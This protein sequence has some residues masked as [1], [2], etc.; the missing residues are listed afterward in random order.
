VQP[1]SSVLFG[2]RWSNNL[3]SF[4]WFGVTKERVRVWCVRFGFGSIP[5]TTAL[6]DF[7]CRGILGA[8]FSFSRRSK[9]LPVRGCLSDT[10]ASR[11]FSRCTASLRDVDIGQWTT[12]GSPQLRRHD[13]VY[14]VRSARIGIPA[15]VKATQRCIGIAVLPWHRTTHAVAPVLT[16]R[17]ISDDMTS[18]SRSD[19]A[20]CYWILQPSLC[21]SK[22]CYASSSAR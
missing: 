1:D 3:G 8:A 13:M 17:N 11:Q 18:C 14:I 2:L 16:S 6:P 15:V 22:Q 9:S 12:A 10:T 5:I 7:R 19:I 21:A 20:R 4:G